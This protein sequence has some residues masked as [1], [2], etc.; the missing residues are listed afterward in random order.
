MDQK[1]LDDLRHAVRS[2]WM[3]GTPTFR[4]H[5]DKELFAV[6]GIKSFNDL[7]PTN[8]N[9]VKI[10]MKDFK[11]VGCEFI[12]CERVYINTEFPGTSCTAD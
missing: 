12:N 10:P 7:Y 1:E 5:Y 3:T 6:L 11:I 8:G 2:A 9:E 4:Q